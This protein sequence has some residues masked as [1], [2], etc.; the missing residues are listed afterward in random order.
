MDGMRA[1]PSDQHRDTAKK[2]RPHEKK[3]KKR[4]KQA[5]CTKP[6]SHTKTEVYDLEDD[7]ERLRLGSANDPPEASQFSATLW[8]EVT[9]KLFLQPRTAKF[10][11]ESLEQFGDM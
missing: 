2:P 10:V 6:A 9:W 3:K 11:T 8:A 1:Q 7:V 5:D 4:L